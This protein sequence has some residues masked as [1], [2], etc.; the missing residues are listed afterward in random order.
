MENKRFRLKEIHTYISIVQLIDNK[1]ITL[2]TIERNEL[3][4]LKEA[5]QKFEEGKNQL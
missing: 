4:S 5:I 2:G 3:P 1:E